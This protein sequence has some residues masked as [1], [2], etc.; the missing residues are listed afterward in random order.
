VDRFNFA[1]SGAQE[2]PP[3]DSPATGNCTADLANNACAVNVQCTHNV[4]VISDIH[5]HVAPPGSDGPIVFDFPHANTFASDV[6]LTP[7]LIADFAAGF[8]YVNV[9]SPNFDAGEIRGQM[10]GVE[11]A[12]VAAAA[13]PT[14][15]EWA[16]LLMMLALATFAAWR[17]R[18]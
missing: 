13:I 9:H 4:Q 2:V 3:N 10:F 16:M 14:L 1:M 8:L 17:M 18:A 6:P 7:R 5:L 12:A 11:S 15:G